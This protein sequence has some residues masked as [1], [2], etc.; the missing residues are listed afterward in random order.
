MQW[1]MY[2]KLLVSIV[3]I[4]QLCLCAEYKALRVV[5]DSSYY[6]D[7]I[8]DWMEKKASESPMFHY[9]KMIFGLQILILMFIILEENETSL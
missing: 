2:P 1:S 4:L 6:T 3:L 7:G 9:W 5:F 8:L